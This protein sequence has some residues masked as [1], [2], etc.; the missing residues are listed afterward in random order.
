M[1]LGIIGAMHQEVSLLLEKME[2]FNEIKYAGIKFFE[3][4]INDTS[5]VV[6]EC[7]VGKVNASMA[8]AILVSMFECNF[9]INTGIAG[10]YNLKQKDVIIASEVYYSD[11][12]ATK[13]GY[14]YGQIP[15]MPTKFYPSVEA[16]LHVKSILNKIGVKYK[17]VAVLSADKFIT[18]VNQLGN[19]NLP[20]EFAT[21]ME[22]A[23]IAQACVKSGVDFI[24]IRYIS[25]NI[26][27]TTIENYNE[28]EE[29]MSKNSVSICL[30]I[31]ENLE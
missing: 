9:I 22:S 7:G 20:S 11:V 10:G 13:F 12:D 14:E 16:T 18:N 6:T 2:H 25:D 4:R 29:E 27:E 30:K 23:A 24:I 3:G 31:I 8:T 5:L 28:F 15:G 19:P 1:R 26:G 21:D 17:N